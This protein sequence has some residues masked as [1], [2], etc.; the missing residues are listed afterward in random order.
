M[1]KVLFA[2]LLVLGDYSEMERLQ[3]G[4]DQSVDK[5]ELALMGALQ[6]FPEEQYCFPHR[7]DVLHF[8][9]SPTGC[10]MV[11]VKVRGIAKHLWLDTGASTSVVSYS[12]AREWGIT[13]ENAS[14]TAT[15]DS[16]QYEVRA[17]PAYVPRLEVGSLSIINHPIIVIADKMLQLPHPKNEAPL[18]IDGIIGWNAI[19][20]TDLVI[21]YGAKTVTFSRPSE[22]LRQR[23]NMFAAIRPIV[24][25]KADDQR[26]LRFG[27]DTGAGFSTICERVLT[28]RELAEM[29]TGMTNIATVGGTKQIKTKS[30]PGRTLRI[31]SNELYLEN[32]KVVADLSDWATFFHIDGVLGSAAFHDRILDI[33]FSNG[34]AA[35]TAAPQF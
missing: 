6:E 8:R 23:K 12:A 17:Q 27:L 2:V 26:V 15:A 31:C 29:Q 33:D 21:N 5:A 22:K 1:P 10:P 25:L 19:K 20:N 32:M 34:I 11:E 13:A 24:S 7:K 28:D 35:L 30:I 16:T 14:L 3:L 18:M 9:S 4:K